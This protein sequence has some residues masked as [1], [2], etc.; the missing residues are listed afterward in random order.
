MNLD[1]RLTEA[2][3]QIREI[4]KVAKQAQEALDI[5]IHERDTVEDFEPVWV[6]DPAFDIAA[7]A[8][9]ALDEALE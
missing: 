3:K 1:K 6:L 9:D 8:K 7:E 2:A 4:E 5:L